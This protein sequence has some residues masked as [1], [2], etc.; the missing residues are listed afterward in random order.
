MTWHEYG[1]IDWRAMTSAAEIDRIDRRKPLRID[2]C[3]GGSSLILR[4]LHG[5]H[6]F[7]AGAVT[8]FASH[9]KH[10]VLRIEFS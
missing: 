4:G 2:H 7:E 1:D 5:G 10:G 3:S 9:P 8:G 6:M